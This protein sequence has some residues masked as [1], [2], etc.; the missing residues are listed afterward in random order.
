MK[1]AFLSLITVILAVAIYAIAPVVT[2]AS[3]AQRTDGSKI[4][5]IYYDVACASDDSVTISLSLS[6]NGG[7]IFSFYPANANLSGDKGRVH[8]GTGKH[9]IWY[10][11]NESQTYDGN[12]FAIKVQ[13]WDTQ[14]V[15]PNFVFVQGGTFSNGT[16]DVTLS[17]IYIDKNEVTQAGYQAVMGTNPSYFSGYP[18]CPVE[19][20]SWFKAI[21]YCNKRSIN[22]GLTPCYSYSTYGANPDNWPAGWN[23]IS[24][25]HT[26][27]SCNWAANG[28]R[29]P[30]EM[31]WMFAA[32]GGNQSQ[33]YTYSGSNDLDAV[34]WYMLNS[35]YTPHN[36]STKASNELGTFDMSGNVWEWCWDILGD[37][38]SG[39]QTDPH[40]AVSGSDRMRRGGSWSSVASSCAVY[41]R[42]FDDATYSD[43]FIGFRCVRV[44]P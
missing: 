25:N 1:R 36:V 27:V 11:G 30:T 7:T 9:I 14:S 43:E 6:D 34:G 19:S 33:N 26:N 37:Y 16:S 13:A 22:E 42:S 4:V 21:E 24:A 39:A 35:G 41:S 10:A 31:E 15:P 8:T 29:L 5:D 18:N 2:N 23:T 38:P 32:K 44:S 20:V 3:F 12:Q 40:G 17:S 28:Y